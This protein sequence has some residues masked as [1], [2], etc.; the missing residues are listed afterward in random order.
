[1]RPEAAAMR[2]VGQ[3]QAGTGMLLGS[4]EASFRD[5]ESYREARP[6]A[7]LVA[8]AEPSRQALATAACCAAA[9]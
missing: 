4:S 6:L 9:R 7:A 8:G 2:P 5:A 1:M 3:D